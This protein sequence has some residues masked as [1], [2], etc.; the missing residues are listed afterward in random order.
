MKLLQRYLLE[1]ILAPFL[2]G[3]MVI[4]VMLLGDHLY[5]LL[6][7]LLV[8]H[9][10][11]GTVFRLLLF[12]LPDMMVRAAPL[13]TILA[14]SLGVN[15]LVRENEWSPMR[16]GGMSPGQML[17]PVHLFGLG[18][19]LLAWIVSEQIAPAAKMEYT[20][21]YT[22][23]SLSD[24]TVV[25]EPQSWFQPPGNESWFFVNSVDE[26]TGEMHNL[27]VFSD[28]RSDYPTVLIARHARLVGERFLLREVVR[29]IYRP[30]GTLYRESE[31]RE[32]EVLFSSLVPQ[33]GGIPQA[34]AEMSSTQLRRMLEDLREKG[35]K[36]PVQ[37]VDLHAKYAVP[38]ACY[39]LA[40]MCVPLN[41]LNA[42]RGSFVGLLI[43]SVLVIV[44]FLTHE[45]GLTLARD[46]FLRQY[47]V[48]GAWL[49]NIVFGVL[50]LA[51]MRRVR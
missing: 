18:A 1:E 27:V 36:Q 40:L 7:L 24:P 41:L 4:L 33:V 26:S 42:Q 39:L 30:D 28:L 48:V 3:V 23:L 49:Q 9:V 46:G 35:V 38:V 29:H 5:T 25:I 15:R 14:V 34:A 17:L 19:G 16:L 43:T 10:E 31:T 21:I 6:N 32:V 50:A 20:R 22:Q 13:A 47:P 12:I 51:L 2:V 8:K 44:Y 11:L 45:I 37:L